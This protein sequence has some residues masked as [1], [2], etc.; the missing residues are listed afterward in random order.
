MKQKVFQIFRSL[1]I[2]AALLVSVP[3]AA[4]AQPSGPMPKDIGFDTHFGAR[5]PAGHRARRR[6]RPAAAARRLPG[7]QEACRAGAR[8]LRV[9]HALLHGPE[10]PRLRAEAERSHAG[11]RLRR[12]RCQHRS[13]GHPRAGGREEGLV[14]GLFRQARGRARAP[15]PDRQRGR[16]EAPRGRRRLQVCLRPDRQAV[17]AP[18]GRHGAHR[19][20]DDRAIPPRG[21]LPASR[22]PPRARRGRPR[23]D[24]DHHRQAPSPLLPLRP[25]AAASTARSPSRPLRSGP[26][27]RWSSWGSDSCS[28]SGAPAMRRKPLGGEGQSGREAPRSVPPGRIQ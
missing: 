14:R 19:R 27:S 25:G 21:R 9:P 3:R 13:R 22:S 11:H 17:R 2:G 8:L 26:C 1:L 16:G 6:G 10:R 5:V 24:R 28:R 12:R 23:D 7:W 18:G 15:L 4:L 20:R